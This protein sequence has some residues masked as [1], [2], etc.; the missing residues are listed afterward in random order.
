MSSLMERIAKA[1]TL[2][3]ADVMSESE[4][5]NTRDLVPT[6]IPVLNIAFSGS[7]KG[8]LTSGIHLFAGPSKHFKTMYALISAASYLHQYPDAVCIFYDNEF[9]SPKEYFASVGINPDRVFH[10]PF[11]SLEELRHDL[12]N[13]MNEI[14]RGDKVIVIIDS[15]GMAASNKEIQDAEDGKEKADMTRAK[16]SKSIFRIITPHVR[17]KDF[18]LIAIQHTY[19]TLEIYSKKVV[20]GG[21]GQYYS[22]DN[23]WIIGRQQDAQGTGTSKELLGY[24]F[25]INVEKS[26]FV[27]EKSK[28]PVNVRKV[29]GIARY[30]GLLELAVMGKF[31]VA[32]KSKG[33]VYQLVN[34]YGEIDERKY[35]KSEIENNADVWKPMLENERFIKYVESLYKVSN[36][37]II[38]D[39]ESDESEIPLAEDMEIP[40]LG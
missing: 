34:E 22:A 39:D 40:V 14:K 27:K 31:I 24:N 15:L 25:I 17:L 30:G 26:R 11:T 28:I 16:V 23:V 3:Y 6:P 38:S 2:E 37:T 36:G 13:T 19:D 29:G 4:V 21:T 33:M 18:P 7:P 10:A 9:G 1:S 32:T 5:F 8:G 12:V 35:K 20:S